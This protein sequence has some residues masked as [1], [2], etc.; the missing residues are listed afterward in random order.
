MRKIN[1]IGDRNSRR[2]V[3]NVINDFKQVTQFQVETTIFK[4]RYIAPAQEFRIGSIP[5][6]TADT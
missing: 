6:F 1:G 5:F 3:A 2:E 4:W